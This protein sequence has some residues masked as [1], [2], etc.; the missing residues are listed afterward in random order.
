MV[1]VALEHAAFHGAA[2]SVATELA[3]RLGC[4]RV[5]IGLRHG[6]HVRV[7][8][9]SHSAEFGKDTNLV[10]AIG[11]AM[12]EAL[13]RLKQ[14]TSGSQSVML[15][16]ALADLL[17]QPGIEAGYRQMRA[18][19]AALGADC[20]LLFTPHLLPIDRGILS[21]I[22]V[23][24]TRPLDDALAP[25]RAM[26]ANEPFVELTTDL[27]ALADVQ[28]RNVVRIGA[29]IPTGVRT[30]TLLVF[31]AID[32]LVKGAAGQAIQN[33]NLM[34]GLDETAGLMR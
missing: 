5:S 21:T 25:F 8:A 20:D 30:P 34:L 31:S 17:T 32:N 13:A 16:R 12:D 6:S 24:L 3:T 19:L 14:A 33:A 26:Y 10:R 29:R 2:T 27:P 11:A 9:L 28:H 23:P 15:E 4:E 22:T 18:S 1:A 7:R